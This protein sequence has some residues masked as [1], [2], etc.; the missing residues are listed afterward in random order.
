MI[1]NLTSTKDDNVDSN[2]YG[3]AIQA[4]YIRFRTLV[5][6]A[7]ACAASD[8][9]ANRGLSRRP[10]HTPGRDETYKPRGKNWEMPPRIIITATAK[11][12]M[13]LHWRKV[14]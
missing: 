7:R 14:S 8:E 2:D 9:V 3:L 5:K 4:G 13:R 12:T 6:I 1:V 10:R 11:L